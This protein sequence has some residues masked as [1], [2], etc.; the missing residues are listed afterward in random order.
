VLFSAT[1]LMV[2]KLC[3]STKDKWNRIHGFEQLAQVITGG[4]FKDGVAVE[5]ALKT[6]SKVCAA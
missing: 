6:G 1:I 2:F 5:S 3:Q 4:Q